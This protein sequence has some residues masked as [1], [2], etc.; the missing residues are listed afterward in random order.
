METKR[1]FR[2]FSLAE[3]GE[4]QK[5]LEEM[6]QKGWKLKA[7]RCSGGMSLRNAYRKTG[8]INW[9]IVMK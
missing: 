5:F 9:I 7:I 3:Y 4:E 2:F 8:F 6:H 1:I